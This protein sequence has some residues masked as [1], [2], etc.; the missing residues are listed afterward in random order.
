M[1]QY[2]EMLWEEVMG[3]KRLILKCLLNIHRIRTTQFRT[4][5]FWQ[6]EHW[7]LGDLCLCC[8]SGSA[9]GLDLRGD[10]RV[11]QTKH[12]GLTLVVLSN[13]WKARDNRQRHQEEDN[14]GHSTRLS[15]LLA[16]FWST[17]LLLLANFWSNANQKA[18]I[19]SCGVEQTQ[20]R[21]EP[22]LG[23]ML[24]SVGEDLVGNLLGPS[25]YL[26]K[27]HGKSGGDWS[28]SPCSRCNT[29][30]NLLIRIPI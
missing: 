22:G 13:C 27:L 20:R 25:G 9:E 28:I 2:Q 7:R 19:C 21:P 11:S 14:L 29:W 6:S 4:G 8:P 15:P 24:D 5:Y 3:E 23:L 1:L 10:V 18:V 16:S 12:S 26:G 17:Y 30:P